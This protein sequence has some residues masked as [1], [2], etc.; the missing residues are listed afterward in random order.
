MLVNRVVL[1]DNLPQPPK[2]NL[3]A[4]QGQQQRAHRAHACRLGRR[5]QAENDRA[6]HGQNQRQRGQQRLADP[7]QQR[8]ERRGL[9]AIGLPGRHGCGP[10]PCH[11]QQ[12]GYIHDD[13]Q[14]AGQQRADETGRRPIPYP[15][16]TRRS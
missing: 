3:S 11:D 13:E 10:Q 9:T 4:K 16:G 5:G 2:F 14:Q 12:P 7:D 6:E 15:A 1:R 8:S